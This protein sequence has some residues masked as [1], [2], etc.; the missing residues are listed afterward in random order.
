MN[1]VDVTGL[2]KDSGFARWDFLRQFVD[3]WSL[4]PDQILLWCKNRP[5]YPL[6]LHVN[7]IVHLHQAY[8]GQMQAQGQQMPNPKDA[9][10]ELQRHLAAEAVRELEGHAS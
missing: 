8:A 5:Q 6:E 10:V 4:R 3:A 9:I 2:S 1:D 7:V